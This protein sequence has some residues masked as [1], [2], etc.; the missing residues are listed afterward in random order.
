M[1]PHWSP[2]L[3][4]ITSCRRIHP[5]DSLAK[6]KYNLLSKNDYGLQTSW[7]YSRTYNELHQ[8]AV[9]E[10]LLLYLKTCNTLRRDVAD[11]GN[12]L[13]AFMSHARYWYNTLCSKICVFMTMK[14]RNITLIEHS[15]PISIL[16]LIA[17]RFKR[18]VTV[19]TTSLWK[20]K[21]VWSAQRA[22]S[23]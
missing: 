23:K 13:Y 2:D 12:V 11:I 9:K 21:C 16:K 5:V 4:W 19:A 6:T 7:N 8:L 1:I 18:T 17:N 20:G 3:S 14:V 22:R 10:S 15:I